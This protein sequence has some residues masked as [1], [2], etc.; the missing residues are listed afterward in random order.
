MSAG[1]VKGPPEVAGLKGEIHYDQP[2]DRIHHFTG[3]IR[4]VDPAGA[5]VPCETN[6]PDGF[7]PVG[8][9]NMVLRG[10]S[11][12]N[13]K[14]I[15]GLV[16]YT[17]KDTKVMRKSGGARSKMSQVEKTMNTCIRIVFAAQVVLCTVTTIAEHIW[18]K[19]HSDD[20]DYIV[21]DTADLWVP[22][23]LGNWFTFLLL[24]N[25]FIPISLYVTVEMVNLLQATLINRDIQMYCSET[26]TAARARTSNLNQ[27]LGQIEYIFSDKT[28][29]LTRNVMEFRQASINSRVYGTF[30]PEATLDDEQRQT[31]RN[32]QRGDDD[33]EAGVVGVDGH[34]LAVPGYP[35]S[36]LPC[37][38][39]TMNSNPTARPGLVSKLTRRQ[40]EAG[41]GTGVGSE[42]ADPSGGTGPG[43][44]PM[45]FKDPHLRA[46]LLESGHS[47]GYG[48]EWDPNGL[49][50]HL[51]NT[52]LPMRVCE[53]ETTSEFIVSRAELAALE[54]YFTLMAVCHTVVPEEDPNAEAGA[55]AIY[56]AESPDEAALAQASRDMGFEFLLR[57]AD[58]IVMRRNFA[59]ADPI[60]YTFHILGT[61]EFN[62]T[63]KRMSVVTRRP[64]GRIF[65]MTKGADNVILER[66]N[67][68]TQYKNTLDAHLTEFAETGL[69]TLV[70][71]Q[72]E[73]PPQEYDQ[74]RQ[75]YTAASLSLVNREEALA[76]V[77]EKYEVNLSVLGATAIEDR[78]QEGVPG[79][80]RDLRRAGIKTWVLTGDKV[81]TAI[82]I[83]FSCR[84]LDPA[85]EL[86]QITS[87]DQLF[88]RNQL[89]GLR[90]KFAPFLADPHGYFRRFLMTAGRTVRRIRSHRSLHMSPDRRS[91]T[92]SSDSVAPNHLRQVAAQ[93]SSS[94]AP[95]AGTSGAG[96]AQTNIA[97]II[98][99]PALNFILGVPDLEKALLTVA[100]CCKSVVAC[101]V[102]PAQKAAIVRM[103]RN[104]ISPKPLTLAIGD[105]ANDVGMIQRAEVGVGISGKEGLQAANAAD[106]SIAQFRFL[107]RLLLVHGRWDYRR[108]TKVVLY[109]FYKNVVITLTLFFFNALTGF[110]GTSFY[111]S[112]I[113]SGYNF[114]L[115]LPIIAIGIVDRDISENTALDHPSV[116][117]VGM[118]YLDLNIKKMLAW[119]GTAV[120]HASIIF[121][122]PYGSYGLEGHK[123]T[124]WD[125][126]NGHEDG[127]EVLGMT[128][129]TCLV[130]AMQLTVS[131]QT[132]TWTWLNV[133]FL[134][135]SMGIW[136]LFIIGYSFMHSFSPEFYGVTVTMFKRPAHWLL[137][138]LVLGTMCFWDFCVEHIRSQFFATP[139]D[140]ARERDKGLFIPDY[141]A[142]TGKHKPQTSYLEA[143][144]R[145]SSLQSNAAAPGT[146]APLS[147]GSGSGV[148][149][150]AIPPGQSARLSVN[151]R[152]KSLARGR[153]GINWGDELTDD[154]RFR[155]GALAANAA[156]QNSRFRGDLDSPGPLAGFPTSPLTGALRAAAASSSADENPSPNAA[157]GSKNELG[158][159][160]GTTPALEP[161][162]IASIP[163]AVPT[164][165]PAEVEL[166][167]TFSGLSANTRTL[168]AQN[169]TTTTNSMRNYISRV[170]SDGS[171][172]SSPLPS[173]SAFSTGQPD[174]H[175]SAPLHSTS[176]PVT[177][178]QTSLIPNAVYEHS[179]RARHRSSSASHIDMLPAVPASAVGWD[180]SVYVPSQAIIT[181]TDRDSREALGIVK[182]REVV[183]SF[184]YSH[185]SRRTMGESRFSKDPY[186]HMAY[187]RY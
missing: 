40:A 101:R 36:S 90:D 166:Q 170:S 50:P 169:T 120:V 23:W 105:G 183:R 144:A 161:T 65:L 74:W 124:I 93:H 160:H 142:G 129:F 60:D 38:S 155:A 43:T 15:L 158:V 29:T 34:G 157:F 118:R 56:Q 139:I 52:E 159:R 31:K 100:R 88:L 89:F 186:E 76:Q 110:S 17:G 75:D 91:D 20:F 53:K 163:S 45:G 70:L 9:R 87:E 137:I 49:A 3:K 72:R 153:S 114:V 152:R 176:S 181:E 54:A 128:T 147:I 94:S 143:W 150:A 187:R 6:G 19:A 92:A 104:G 8:P 86:I 138:I 41:P 64:D 106:F 12:R 21:R 96:I 107:K 16:V 84:L 123:G 4:L 25:N 174:P 119:I 37:P 117:A 125:G 95:A 112:L 48:E 63:R 61:H 73:F 131:Q 116:Y 14:W 127:L 180:G 122:I 149:G 136:Y 42:G 68:T 145:T 66:S 32:P 51:P 99:G 173:P 134:A 27:D 22:D 133:F 184:A 82:N 7:S 85:M 2:N 103:V 171:D 162:E 33:L 5:T 178:I 11:L 126:T 140:A 46:M 175:K 67:A 13:T 168:L 132:W 35:K 113:Y 24:F 164:T 28:G 167:T 135:L 77:A 165:Y 58:S 26:N 108:M 109:S 59:N 148:L 115:G 57:N 10:C 62:S 146:P 44:P 78:L 121:W 102:S 71:A 1:H 151:L 69:R 47:K 179:G 83:G 130:W 154:E 80:I 111:E 177:N 185:A 172:T 97:I 39:L 81:E 55:P 156:M 30:V 182:P 18:Y 141:F 79:T 98:T